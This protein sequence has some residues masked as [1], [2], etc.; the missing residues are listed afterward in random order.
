MKKFFVLVPLIAVAFVSFSFVKK[1]PSSAVSK[2]LVFPVAGKRSYVGSFW[3]DVRDAG[4]RSH[5]GIDIFAKKGTPVVAICDGVIVSRGTTPR[6]GKVLWLQSSGH[7]WSVYYA[8]LN[9]QKVRKGQ[10]VK[11]G[12]VIGTVGKTGNA[13]YTPPHLHFGIYTGKGAVNPL[14]YVKSSKKIVSPKM[15][16]T[17][18]KKTAK[19]AGRTARTARR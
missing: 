12:Q 8:H 4:K 15:P 1:K 16:Q 2:S 5:E 18:K 14:P 11:K 10:F 7:P 17:S 3:G 19:K 13:K 9:E 6:G